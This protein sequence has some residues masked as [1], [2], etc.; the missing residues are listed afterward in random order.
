MNLN[1]LQDHVRSRIRAIE[2]LGSKTYDL[3]ALDRLDAAK[4]ALEQLN[5]KL[6]RD[7][8]TIEHDPV[9]KP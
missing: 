8:P 1:V 9:Q 2:R 3:V 4:A 5:A 7:Y 6:D